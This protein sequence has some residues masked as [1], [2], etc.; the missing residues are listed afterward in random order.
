MQDQQYNRQPKNVSDLILFII[1]REPDTR[2]RPI[3]NDQQM[4]PINIIRATTKYSR[5]E[6]QK[7]PKFEYKMKTN[8]RIDMGRMKCQTPNW[9]GHALLEDWIPS[10]IWP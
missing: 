1:V 10:T 7:P 6:E 9:I 2:V 4:D 3:W 8:T 5:K